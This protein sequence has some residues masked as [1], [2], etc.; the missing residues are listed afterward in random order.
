MG[1]NG[2][3]STVI[4]NKENASKI[5]RLIQQTGDEL[6]GKLPDHPNHPKG[7]NPYAHVA[8]MV[9]NHFG[10]SYK[11]V[12]DDKMEEVKEYLNYLRENPE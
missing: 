12:S 6:L 8:L 3:F 4:L 5:W 2:S 9:K 11:D 1:P 10:M 7:R